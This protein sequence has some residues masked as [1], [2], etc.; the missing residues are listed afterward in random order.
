MKST[1]DL[2]DAYADEAQ[3][4][5]LQFRCYGRR[6]RF[7][8]PVS[9]VLCLEDNVLVRESLSHDSPGGVLV[10]DGHG[11]LRSALLTRT[12]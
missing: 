12:A 9:T 11:S 4:C 1:A 2:V 5:E 7:C 3:S 10:V 8:G 6:K